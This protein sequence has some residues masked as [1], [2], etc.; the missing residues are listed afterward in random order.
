M[1]DNFSG[2]ETCP[3]TTHVTQGSLQASKKI[4]VGDLKVPMREINLSDG[5]S[6]TVYDSSGPYT[7]ESAQLDIM[8]GLPRVRGKWIFE[9]GDVERVEGRKVKPVDNGH[10]EDSYIT[11]E[12][13]PVSPEKPLRAK[14]GANVTQMH[15]AKKGIITPEMEY[16]AVRENEGRKTVHER[17]KDGESF[18]ANIPEFITP[19]FV[20]KE[21]AEGRAII[22]ANINHPESEPMIIG[23]NFLVKVNANIGNSSVTSSIG[24]EVDKMVWALRW[25]SDTVMDLSTGNNIHDTREWI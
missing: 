20:R 24:E 6:L 8:R 14:A 15:Y 17:A 11:H 10:K 13:F 2:R 3:S 12:R 23:R 19:K 9:R 22:P 1:A 16:I 21:V 25:G 7:D 5:E 4:Y 18:G